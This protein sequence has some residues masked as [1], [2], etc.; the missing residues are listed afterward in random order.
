MK[1]KAT[2]NTQTAN[3]R[4]NEFYVNAL[5]SK[6]PKDMDTLYRDHFEMIKNL[7]VRSGGTE[8]EA[9]DLFQEGLIIIYSKVQ[10]DTLTLT[11]QFRTYLFRV[12]RNLYLKSLRKSGRSVGMEDF[13]FIAD[14]NQEEAERLALLTQ[15]KDLLNQKLNLLK[16]DER[17]LMKLCFAGKKM[18]EIATLMGY[19]SENYAK[20][21]KSLIKHKL[22]SI[23]QQD[24]MFMELAY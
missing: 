5:K 15:R 22:I 17:K 16:E 9:S 24:R 18:K 1:T 21:K 10:S 2:N 6:N 4:S 12:C 20:K 8:A 3:F 19:K 13:S 11:C 14:E 7:I 23:I